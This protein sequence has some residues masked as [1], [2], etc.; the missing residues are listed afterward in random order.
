M[1]NKLG[2]WFPTIHAGTGADIFTIR[3]VSALSARNIP[4]EI[5]WLPHRA[6]YAPWSVEIPH[7]PKWATVVHINSWLHQRFIPKGLPLVVTL[8]SSVHDPAL[9]PYKNLLRTLYHRFWIKFC[10]AHSLKCAS[11]VTAV[12]QYTA[13]QAT[14][15]FGRKD[16]EVFYNWVDTDLFCPDAHPHPHYPFRLLF[17]GKPSILK[18]ADLLPAIMRMLGS[19]F[20]LRYTGKLENVSVL[21]LPK[22]MVSIGRLYSEKEIVTA[23]RA[24]DA[25]LFP[26]R[27]EGLSL[28]MLEA[29][30]CGLPIIAARASSLPEIVKHNK[31]GFLCPLDEPRAFVEA[32]KKLRTPDVWSSYSDASRSRAITYFEKN[33]RVSAW[34]ILY[35]RLSRSY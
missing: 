32:A 17:V 33:D 30:S 28:A 23:Y 11:V 26:S 3:L 27:L 35:K 21:N 22:N 6:E 19:D 8:H 1:T 20:E 16:I 9:K 14:R 10:E 31:T 7:P 15:S 5:A 29:Q 25:L 12:S 24:A 4:A 18:G 34:V 13:D 2:V